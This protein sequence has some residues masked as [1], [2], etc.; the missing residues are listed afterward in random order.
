MKSDRLTSEEFT[1][2]ALELQATQPEEIKQ[3]RM[4]NWPRYREICAQVSEETPEK[5]S[6]LNT[7][8]IKEFLE[9]ERN[10]IMEIIKTVTS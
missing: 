6:N 8:S 10:R 2:L 3:F 5:F 9:W 7:N 4:S 1:L